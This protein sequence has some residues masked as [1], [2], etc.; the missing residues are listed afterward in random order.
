[1]QWQPTFADYTL[2]VRPLNYSNS[3]HRRSDGQ[4]CDFILTS[5]TC[6]DGCD[7]VFV[8]CLRQSGA[9]QNSNDD[10]C[11]LGR[12]TNGEVQST[13]NLVFTPNFTLPF[14]GGV[15]PVSTAY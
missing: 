2:T 7:N 4:C 3:A 12:Y 5:T 13:D 11:P 15:W 1:M 9:L 14:T 8:F 6:V 10:S